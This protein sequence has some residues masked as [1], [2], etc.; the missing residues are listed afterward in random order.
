MYCLHT[1]SEQGHCAHSLLPLHLLA[2]Q[3]TNK[4]LPKQHCLPAGAFHRLNHI[5]ELI[6]ISCDRI[7][8]LNRMEVMILIRFHG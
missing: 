5:Q 8:Y 4:T 7:F 1:I 6:R 3:G 2:M